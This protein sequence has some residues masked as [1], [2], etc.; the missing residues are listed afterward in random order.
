MEEVLRL[1]PQ[2]S[3]YRVYRQQL[4]KELSEDW[5]DLLEHDCKSSDV[6]FALGKLLLNE[7]RLVEARSVFMQGLA[8]FPLDVNAYQG[9]ALS[10]YLDNKYQ[11]ALDFFQ[12]MYRVHNISN[13]TISTLED[14][15]KLKGHSWLEEFRYEER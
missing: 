6:V 8:Q 2:Q 15:A 5:R 10:F 12:Y 11:Y 9:L 1:A 7:R 14:V 13:E 4:T 3:Y